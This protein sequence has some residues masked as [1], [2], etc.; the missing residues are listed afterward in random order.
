M[1]LPNNISLLKIPYVNQ[2]WIIHV[3]V[4][5]FNSRKYTKELVKSGILGV[6]KV[7]LPNI[8]KFVISLV[9]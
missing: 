6:P 1:I 2:E 5:F 7:M 3:S 9:A 4:I 8:S